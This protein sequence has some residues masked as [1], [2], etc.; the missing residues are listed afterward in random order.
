MV[1]GWLRGLG[2]R[3]AGALEFA[4]VAAI[5]VVGGIALAGMSAAAGSAPPWVAAVGFAPVLVTIGCVPAIV[6]AA[7]IGWVGGPRVAARS[8]DALAPTV[9]AWLGN[10]LLIAILLSGFMAGGAFISLADKGLFDGVVYALQIFVAFFALTMFVGVLLFGLPGFLI[11][12]VSAFIWT[13]WMRRTF[14]MT[15]SPA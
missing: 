11:A 15:A 5:W 13:H 6:V 10:A 3:R 9:L 4:V 7:V 12:G 2:P 1:T 14:P 8:W